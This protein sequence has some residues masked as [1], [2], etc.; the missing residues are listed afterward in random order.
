M[1]DREEGKI[2]TVQAGGLGEMGRKRWE[3]ICYIKQIIRLVKE[4]PPVSAPREDEASN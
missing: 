2:V 4:R 1:A 3:E